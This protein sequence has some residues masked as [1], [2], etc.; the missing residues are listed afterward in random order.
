MEDCEN[1]EIT[2]PVALFYFYLGNASEKSIRPMI[3]FNTKLLEV[4]L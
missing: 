2:T 4:A 1:S 3:L